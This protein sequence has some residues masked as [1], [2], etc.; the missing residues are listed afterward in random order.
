MRR[1]S[2]REKVLLGIL[3]IL[4][5]ISGYVMFVYMPVQETTQRL[6][7]DI[8]S[9]EELL[10]AYETKVSEKT[11]MEQELKELF[12]TNPNPV[13]LPAYNN[14]QNIMVELNRIL[15]QTSDYSVQFTSENTEDTIVRRNVTVQYRC[16]SY[17]LAKQT[18]TQLHDS[19]YRCMLDDVTISEQENG[20]TGVV[21]NIVFFEYQ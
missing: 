2:I 20:Q 17:E 1:L 9:G 12:A 7:Q 10:L 14:V 18:L 3:L 15:E 6:E 19:Q 11:R 8:A 21:A 4:V 13:S 5:L 16:G